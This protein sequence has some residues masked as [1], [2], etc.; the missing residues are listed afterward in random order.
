MKAPTGPFTDEER[1]QYK[2]EIINL[3]AYVIG[4]VTQVLTCQQVQVLSGKKVIY[5][6]QK[7]RSFCVFVEYM[8]LNFF[9][10]PSRIIVWFLI[11]PLCCSGKRKSWGGRS[12]QRIYSWN[13]RMKKELLPGTNGKSIVLPLRRWATPKLQRRLQA[14]NSFVLYMCFFMLTWD[15]ICER[16]RLPIST[17]QSQN[18]ITSKFVSVC[19][20]NNT[21]SN[22]TIVKI[23]K[24][25]T[26]FNSIQFNS[27]QLL[28]WC[29]TELI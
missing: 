21:D 14:Q 6:S 7:V 25:N 26:V 10:S 16:E 3:Q 11:S 5:H 15:M 1:N 8:S 19:G 24:K 22:C 18:N 13:L 12:H 17:I 27:I 23:L 9:P 28:L 2:K 29:T 4:N 20:L